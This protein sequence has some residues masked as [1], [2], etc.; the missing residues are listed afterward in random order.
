MKISKRRIEFTVVGLIAVS[1]AGV[2]I[3]QDAAANIT[4]RKNDM[5]TIQAN[6]LIVN[7]KAGKRDLPAAKEAAGKLNAAFKDLAT[8][9]TPGSGSSAGA[10]ATRAKDDIFANPAAFKAKLDHAIDLTDKVVTATN[11]TD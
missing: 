3:A 9:F 10:G 8:R 5:R 11:G 7:D 1:L 4:A 2:A 6:M